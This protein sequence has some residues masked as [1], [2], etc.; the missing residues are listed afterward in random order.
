M[1]II[2][3]ELIKLKLHQKMLPGRWSFLGYQYKYAF[4]HWIAL[5]DLITTATDLKYL[6]IHIDIAYRYILLMT[7]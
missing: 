6:A 5:V 4:G 1:R 7:R 3:L 2:I